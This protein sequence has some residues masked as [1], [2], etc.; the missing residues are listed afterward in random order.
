MIEVRHLRLMVE[1]DRSGSLSEAARRLGY[2]QP[3]ITQQLKILERQLGTPLVSRARGA[4]HLTEPGRLLLHHASEIL[5]KLDLAQLEIEAVIGMR[6]GNVRVACFPSFAAAL[7]PSAF[8]RLRRDFP[9]V[10]LSLTEG[11]P[12]TVL[13]QLSR[14]ECDLA[15]VYHYET[16][17][18]S[19]PRTP[20]GAPADAR[21]I[22]LLREDVFVAMASSHPLAAA[23][24]VELSALASED[25]IAGCP[26]CRHHLVE[27]CESVGFRPRIV[28]ETDDCVALQ[29]LAGVGLG[30]AFISGLMFTAAP[31]E[32]PLALKHVSPRAQRVVSVVCSSAMA[33]VPAVARMI[34]AFTGSAE[35]IVD[36]RQ[37]F[38]L[39]RA[40]QRPSKQSTAS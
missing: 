8:A 25:W 15:V 36:D 20:L 1:I 28:F 11:E 29:G 23:P 17:D 9:E 14:G 4:M 19:E 13:A 5:A 37:R 18:A 35:Q 16:A 32:F 34:E 12:E 10:S 24:F 21:W 7:V 40:S 38:G 22:P 30:I 39:H 6:G 26:L 33:R 3:A 31:S 2:S 27:A